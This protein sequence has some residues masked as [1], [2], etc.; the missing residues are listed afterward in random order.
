MGTDAMRDYSVMGEMWL[1]VTD[2]GMI[3]CASRARDDTA[4]DEVPQGMLDFRAQGYIVKKVSF[5]HAG[6]VDGPMRASLLGHF[7]EEWNQR[8]ANAGY[9]EH[10][11]PE[12][13]QN[14][15]N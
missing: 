15:T 7:I 12:G 5:D 3:K 9:V 10:E 14:G 8:L 13:P 11:I 2:D 6:L 1:A 4:V